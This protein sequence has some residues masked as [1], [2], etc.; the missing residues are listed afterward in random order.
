MRTVHTN[1]AAWTAIAALIMIVAVSG[2]NKEEKTETAEGC[3]DCGNPEHASVA[4][5]PVQLPAAAPLPD[6]IVTVN[7]KKLMRADVEKELAIMES[8]PQ[9]AAIPPEQAQMFKQR[10][11]SQMIDR[12][13]NQEVL[14]AEANKQNITVTD[15]EIDAT[16]EQIKG[17]LPPG[18]T[19]EQVMEERGLEMAKLRSD[20]VT[21]LKI[22]SL[23]EKQA[24]A[25]PAATD[26]A[27]AA[28]YEAQ[29]DQFNMPESAQ[30]R[31]ILVKVDAGAD[32][33]AKAAK[34][35]E[36][37]GFRQQLIDGTAEFEKLASEHSACPSGKRGGDLGDFPRGQ[38]VPEFDK[39]AFEQ[40]L[41]VVGPVIETQFGY[42][43]VEVT[44]RTEA[45]QRPLEDVK[46]QIAQQL[47]GRGKQQAVQAYIASLREGAEIKY[48]D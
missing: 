19:L 10:A 47:T 44:G 32:D 7:G 48:G 42:H 17:S 23:L 25:V 24:D 21:D 6:T 33:E 30:A 2:C 46:D 12:F 11:Q 40:E 29:K 14:G 16:L 41:N 4:S 13:V 38:M 31:H 5:A 15:E 3:S 27:I 37:E 20:I 22:R 43:I 9:F 35:A 1:K 28:F 45:G 36:I 26:E 39:A 18:Q 34:K 8:S